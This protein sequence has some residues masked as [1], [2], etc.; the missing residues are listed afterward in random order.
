MEALPPALPSMWRL[1]KLGY[2]H[3]PGMML[4]AFGLALLS[5]LPDALI[6]LWLALLGAGIVAGRPA[7][8]HAAAIGLGVS[9]VGTWFLRIV[10]TRV[11]RRFRDKVTIAL[12]SHVARLQASVATIAHHERPEYLD[13]LSVLRDQVFVLDHMYMSVFATCGWMVRLGV[14][15]ALLVSIHPLLVLLALCALPTVLTSSWRPAVERAAQERGAPSMRLSRHFFTLATTPA[16]GKEVRVTGIG[17]R[18]RTGRRQAWERWHGPIAATRW[19]SAAWH[20]V[21]WAVFGSAYVGAVVFVS[22]VLARSAAEVLLVLAAGSRLSSYVGATV[23]EIGFLRGIWMDGSRRLAWLEDYAASFM[24]AADLPVPASLRQGIRLEHVSFAYPGT[25]RLV[26]DDVS[27]AIPAGSV[28]AVVGENGAGKTTLVKLLAKMYEPS[29]G[30]LFADDTPLSRVRADEWR[31]R[32]SG[33]FQDFF[34]FEFRAR[35]TV[36]VGDVAR[37]DEETAVATAVAR[38]GADDVVVRLKA[39]LDTQLGPT[40][41][42]GVEVSFGQ[43]QKLALAR[44]FMRDEPLLLILDEPTAALDAETEHALFERYASAARSGSRGTGRI[45]VLVSHRFSTVRMADLILVLDG[46]RLAEAGTH[47][48]LMARGGHYAQSYAIQAAAYR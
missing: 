32:L 9:A 39:G 45:T 18:L 26:L 25:S 41:P 19:Q 1:C 12:E 23:G 30:A 8:I 17:D 43:W 27:F 16:P 14:T 35:H 3:E 37:M 29:S 24:A 36:G 13:R 38:A 5:A 34:R 33:A 20:T 46:A 47:D 22:S 4:A 44:G 21:A 2:R 28:L 7:Q 6:A 10:S 42:D 40:W 15:I 31:G 11:Q 48:E